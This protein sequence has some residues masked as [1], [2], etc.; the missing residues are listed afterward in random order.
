VR[1]EGFWAGESETNGMCKLCKLCP[2][3]SA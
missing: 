3:G 1:R 2:P